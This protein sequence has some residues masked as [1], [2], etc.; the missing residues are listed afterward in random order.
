MRIVGRIVCCGAI[1]ASTLFVSANVAPANLPMERHM[2][3]QVMIQ[4]DPELTK[5]PSIKIDSI[6]ANVPVDDRL[7]ADEA[8]DQPFL[9]ALKDGMEWYLTQRGVRV[10]ES[11][12]D[13]RI[14][15]VIESYEGFKGW[16]HWGVDV[17]LGLKLFRGG[18]KVQSLSIHSLLKYSSDK[19]VQLQEEP[20]Y[21]AQG[22]SVTFQEVLFTR[23]GIDICEK[24]IDGLKEGQTHLTSPVSGGN[25]TKR[26]GS[27]SIDASVPNAE[28]RVDGQLVGTVPLSG[29]PLPEGHHLIEVSK[30]GYKAWK[31]DVLIIAGATSRL[32]AELEPESAQK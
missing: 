1:L 22:L 30:K 31:N 23:V 19:E 27:I 15:G 26:Q 4:K 20:K 14:A 29:L 3:L 25:E 28:V 24:L 21:K 16:G 5:L 12:E 2:K 17:T 7:N 10:V 11:D 18:E 6:L 8:F 32:V 13:L 9:Q